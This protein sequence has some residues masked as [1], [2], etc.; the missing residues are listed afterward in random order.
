MN[1]SSVTFTI[2]WEPPLNT[3][4]DFHYLLKYKAAHPDDYP[5]A[6][7]ETV[8]LTTVR[9]D[10][11][12]Q[13]SYQF[14][15]ALPFAD[16]TITLTPVNTK[17]NRSPDS[18]TGQGRTIA[19][20]PTAVTELE[21]VAVD[22]TMLM[23]SWEL[24]VYPNG[25]LSQ[26]LVHY[27]ESIDEQSQSDLTGYT[28]IPVTYP[29]KT[30][31]I[32]GL[33]PFT[34]YTVI[35]QA[36]GEGNLLGE[37]SMKEMRT[38]TA[39]DTPPP[40]DPTPDTGRTTLDINLPDPDRIDTGPVIFYAVI[41]I[42]ITD[43]FNKDSPPD[44]TVYYSAGPYNAM[45]E[46]P[47]EAYI[48]A[49][50]TDRT[51]VPGVFTIGDGSM[52]QANDEIYEN[53]RLSS[54]T[55]YAYIIRID[56]ESDTS[57]PVI[58]HTEFEFFKTDP[59][60]P[61][62]AA[63]VG[64]SVTIVLLLLVAVVVAFVVFCIWWRRRAYKSLFEGE[65]A[66][67]SATMRQGIQMQ[68]VIINP[69]PISPFSGT[70]EPIP[71]EK[72]KDHVERMHSNDDYLFSEEYNS[73]EP[74]HAPTSIACHLS[75]NISKNRYANI[76]AYDHSRVKLTEDPNKEGSDYINANHIDGYKQRKGFI[77][78]Q[79]TVCLAVSSLHVFFSVCRP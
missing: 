77:A 5:E 48:T 1:E 71:L 49:A 64:A 57:E 30:A 7:R 55:D 9:I 50:W 56:I 37:E 10:D 60:P 14:N 51:E 42:R 2:T 38:Y 33:D 44:E 35:V 28:I 63:A 45:A 58:F 68:Q 15:G 36:V 66:E 54:D 47:Q 3:F 6:R 39:T 62:N 43:M 41:V 75:C 4:G 74:N 53:V 25:P 31:T 12:N 20:E 34:S 76:V 29:Q 18:T 73:I 40:V 8:E 22:S 19:I 32:G 69:Q 52:T 11:G 79:G 59:N 72:F 23:V 46:P 61:S 26:Y 65:I 17:L 21:V 78:A 13:R 70:M 67:T 24:P 16:Y 27:R